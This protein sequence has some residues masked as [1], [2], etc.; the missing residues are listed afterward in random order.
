MWMG[1]L[2]D[3]EGRRVETHASHNQHFLFIGMLTYHAMP[4]YSGEF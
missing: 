1:G 3:V 4:V 2:G